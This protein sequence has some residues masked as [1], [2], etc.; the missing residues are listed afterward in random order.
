[1]K[2]LAK[3]KPPGRFRLLFKT[4]RFVFLIVNRLGGSLILIIALLFLF[5][6]YLRKSPSH[7]LGPPQASI[8]R[9]TRYTPDSTEESQECGCRNADLC[10]TIVPVGSFRPPQD[11]TPLSTGTLT[12]QKAFRRE[13][14]RKVTMA[15]WDAY[16]Q[17]AWGADE[18]QPMSKKGSEVL[19][20]MGVTIVESVGTLYIMNLTS[21]Y[22]KARD[23]VQDSLIFDDVQQFVPVY[24]VTTRILGGL[25][26][27]YQL[28]G[29]SMF[30]QKAEDL[31][32]RLSGA[33]NSANGIPY[34]TCHLGGPHR[35]L[36][37]LPVDALSAIDDGFECY[38]ETT[39][40]TEAGGISL[41]FRALAFHSLSPSIRALRCRADRAVQAVIES[42]PRLLSQFLTEEFQNPTAPRSPNGLIGSK[43]NAPVKESYLSSADSY[44]SYVVK[45]WHSAVNAIGGG[46]TVDT[47]ATF[48]KPARAFYE[49][50]VKAWRQG[51]SCEA[52]LR[53][54]LDASMH[55]LLKRA[56][57]E[58][59]T[60]DLYLRTFDVDN[61][62]D[63][64]VVDQSMCYLPAVFHLA[65]QHKNISERRLDQWRDVAAGITKSCVSMYDRFPGYLGGE[66]ARYNGGVWVTK[67]AYRLQADL[68]EAVFYMSRST[69]EPKYAEI[70]WRILQNMELQCKLSSGAFTV[71]EERN[72]GSITKGDKM[73]SE[74]LGSTLKLLYLTFTDDDVLSLTDYVFNRAGHPL[75]VTPALGAINNCH[76]NLL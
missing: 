75:L 59:P 46:P 44:Y 14:I 33:F 22:E 72:I 62:S 45:A 52:Y 43:N 39:S 5:M 11:V 26:S 53:Y 54:P 28:T 56:I 76:S 2:I 66:S 30:F 68:V 25:I 57:H 12:Q 73:P 67:G 24:D 64:A 29:D 20:N 34:P 27:A 23:W 16:V 10:S 37:G 60:H 51:G 65:A 6:S 42:G 35:N 70:A 32:R 15:A 69:K 40:Q 41:E 74:F 36:S 3:T 21:R 63:E 8:V 38:G 7:I 49:Y 50:L 55:M 18:L 47:T 4:L 19:G 48:S 9:R 31:G 1:M 58:S 61:E 13:H 71:L 17:D